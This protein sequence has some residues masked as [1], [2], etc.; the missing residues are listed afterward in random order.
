MLK[1]LSWGKLI[2][3]HLKEKHF[4]FTANPESPCL[5]V[6]LFKSLLPSKLI[7]SLL[8]LS[9]SFIAC[10][11]KKDEYVRFNKISFHQNLSAYA[12]FNGAMNKLIP[13]EGVTEYKLNA[14]LFTD[15]ALK[16]RLVKIP[17]GEKIEV[18]KEDVFNFPEGTII[19]KTFYYEKDTNTKHIIETRLLIKANNVWNVAVYQWND[20]QDGAILIKNGAT[21]NI[22]TSLKGGVIDELNYKIPSLAD[23]ITCHKQGEEISP[24]GPKISNLIISV[25]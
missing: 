13:N 4:N 25:R 10:K 24:I 1:K 7:C 23:C 11:E 22:K 19:A 9:F 2:R 3:G 5:T 20:H 8:L 15:Y 6:N 14:T 12:L 18:N 16:Q 17:E 21:V